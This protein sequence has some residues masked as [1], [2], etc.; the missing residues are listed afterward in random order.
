MRFIKLAVVLLL[1]IG[2]ASCDRF[3]HDFGKI[4]FVQELFEPLQTAMANHN[5]L[6]QLMAF[7]QDGYMH[8]AVDKAAREQFYHTLDQLYGGEGGNYRLDPVFESYNAS[9]ESV[10]WELR[11]WRDGLESSLLASFPFTD[12]KIVKVD[13]AW[14]FYGNQIASLEQGNK[15][16]IIFESFTYTTCPNCPAVEEVMHSL[17]AQYPSQ[18]SYVEYHIGDPLQAPTNMG[19][20]VYYGV[21]PMPA[22]VFQGME[23]RLSAN[24]ETLQA[25]L[26]FVRNM[27]ENQ[28]QLHLRDLQFEV[29]S[30]SVSG[31]V[32]L[33][34][35]AGTIDQTDLKLRVH[36]IEK[37][38]ATTNSV[39]APCT[40][41]VLGSATIDLA[42]AD[43]TH[44][45]NFQVNIPGTI[46]SDAAIVIYAQRMSAVFN[47]DAMIYNGLER[48]LAPI[49][50]KGE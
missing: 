29:N 2:L 5:D 23:K 39:G 14:K 47:N 15:Q 28:P 36:I 40:N 11:I 3:D 9:N 12:E 6:T 48:S 31:S 1:A 18:F 42:T 26:S 50:L 49:E 22:T 38:S 35:G 44:S 16:R 20:F 43:L 13:G 25:Y 24:P 21:S 8:N 46:P 41:V 34:P 19:T 45:V 7:Y 27:L 37:V 32:R 30:P 17:A 10:N 4:D 33:A